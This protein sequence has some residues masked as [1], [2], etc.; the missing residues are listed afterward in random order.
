[1]DSKP[2]YQAWSRWLGSRLPSRRFYAFCIMLCEI[3]RATDP[4]G[5]DERPAGRV[6]PLPLRRSNVLYAALS[7]ACK[8]PARN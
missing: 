2:P 6:A 3:G 1:M 4:R 5:G 8:R 7:T